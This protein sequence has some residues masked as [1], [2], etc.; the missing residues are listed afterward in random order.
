MF[1][2]HSDGGKVVPLVSSKPTCC[3]DSVMIEMAWTVE[4][5]PVQVSSK[6][7]RRI[8]VDPLEYVA[9]GGNDV[10]GSAFALLSFYLCWR[11]SPPPEWQP[12]PEGQ[13]GLECRRTLVCG[14]LSELT[15]LLVCL[16]L[17]PV[18]LPGPDLGPD[19]GSWTS[20]AQYLWRQKTETMT[21]SS[22]LQLPPGW[23]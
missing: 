21:S 14:R 17:S 5:G 15:S 22:D 4:L 18:R 12:P 1:R 9:R 7:I 13:D 20:V 19:L 6:R 16:F 23:R 11:G 10:F 3:S 8:G 2:L